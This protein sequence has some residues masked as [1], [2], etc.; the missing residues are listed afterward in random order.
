MLEVIMAEDDFAYGYA[1]GKKRERLYR[2]VLR[3]A[4]SALRRRGADAAAEAA[5]ARRHMA[6]LA[7]RYPAYLE[8]VSGLARALGEEPREVM[9]GGLAL[10]STAATGCT[11]FAAVPPAT[12]DGRVYVSWNFDLPPWIRLIVGR[13]PLY[14]RDIAGYKPYV[15][16]G[17][18][19]LFGIGV[20]NGDGLCSCV[21]SVGSMDGGEGLTFFELNNLAMETQSTVD[22][23]VSVWRDNPREVV[24]GLAISIIM[25]ANDIFADM[26]G[27]AVVIE[28]SHH[29]MAVERAS[30]H[31]GVLASANHHQFLDRSLSGGADPSI[32]PLIAGSFARLARMWELLD[33]FRGD[34]DH[35][36][37]RMIT[38]DHGLNYS[39]LAEF[40]MERSLYDERVD[41]ATICCHPWN[42]F[43]HLRRLELVEALVE[44]NVART[45][46]NFLMDPARCTI[47]MTPGNPCREQYV[48]V[49]LGDALRMEWADRAR[50]EIDY[51]PEW[52]PKAKARRIDVFRRPRATRT[53][54]WMRYIGLGIFRSLD[55]LLSSHVLKE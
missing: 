10:A 4:M 17:L 43:R 39:T 20:M 45:L 40:G 29:H 54:D 36:T 53:S 44:F 23:A 8:R 42:F 49:W 21:N 18:P 41:D 9:A 15:C 50:E 28:H 48:P 26:N 55:N 6:L 34:I 2:G 38:R 14:V 31:G 11:N 37:A 30:D 51:A 46:N 7:E 25:N 5:R 16:M 19:V 32:E 3:Y 1:A 24:P 27:E 35:L 13:M 47:Y 33:L 52:R 12:S 22:G